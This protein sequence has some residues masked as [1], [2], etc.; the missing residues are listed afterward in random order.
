MQVEHT[1]SKANILKMATLGVRAFSHQTFQVYHIYHVHC[2]FMLGY[3]CR[4]T[5]ICG[6][7]KDGS[8]LID[9]FYIKQLF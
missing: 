6:T 4:I 3:T 5:V 7:L 1:M 2:N 9:I 8:R